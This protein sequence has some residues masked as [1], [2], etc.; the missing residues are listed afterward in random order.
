M[1]SPL[2]PERKQEIREHI[3]GARRLA[4]ELDIDP[5]HTINLSDLYESH[6][7]L[8]EALGR[9]LRERSVCASNRCAD[10]G[11]L[12]CRYAQAHA[13]LRKAGVEV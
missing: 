11:H 9:I 8:I 1:T 5:A 4:A 12:T 2:T 13:A 7:A 10:L 3:Q 6:E